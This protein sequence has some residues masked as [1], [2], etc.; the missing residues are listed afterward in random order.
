MSQPL[1]SFIAEEAPLEPIDIV[2]DILRDIESLP[3][4]MELH[5]MMQE[6]GLVELMRSLGAL[7]D[8]DRAR[9][10][11]YLARHCRGQLRVRQLPSG[12]LILELAGETRLDESA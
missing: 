9:L 5:Y 1:L 8:A 6:P 12:A 4:L 10:R 3:R 11:A 7:P 2:C